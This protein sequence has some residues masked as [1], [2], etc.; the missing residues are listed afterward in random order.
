MKK[1]KF[2]KIIDHF[3]LILAIFAFTLCFLLILYNMFTNKTCDAYTI[4]ELA[5]IGILDALFIILPFTIRNYVDELYIDEKNIKINYFDKGKNYTKIFN[6]DDIDS[7]HTDIDI[8]QNLK[9]RVFSIDFYI[10][11]KDSSEEQKF[12]NCTSWPIVLRSL[13]DIQ[14]MIPNFTYTINSEILYL[15]NKWLYYAENKKFKDS[16]IKSDKIRNLSVLIFIIGF[17][18]FFAL[19]FKFCCS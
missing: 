16:D 13:F 4:F 11:I 3:L 19:I 12:C 5:L 15:K 6:L 14:E 10:K 8:R 18:V 7:F 9:F 1:V 2:N 17:I